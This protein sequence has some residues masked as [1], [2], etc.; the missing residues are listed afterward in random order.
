MK[1]DTMIVLCFIRQLIDTRD[2]FYNA[3]KE[4]W[5]ENRLRDRQT[6]AG[7]L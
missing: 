1:E 6:V 2:E 5:D 3:E 7:Q 4:F